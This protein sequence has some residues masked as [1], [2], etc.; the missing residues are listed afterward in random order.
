MDA[1]REGWDKS[2]KDDEPLSVVM[3]DID[4]FKLVNDG[5]G[6][7][8]GDEV[9]KATAKVLRTIVEP[10]ASVCRIGG[11]EFVVVLPSATLDA[12]IEY[13]EKL[14]QAV[15]SHSMRAG[16]FEGTV[17]VSAGV[18]TRDREARDFEHLLK[19][20][21]EGLYRAK[22]GGRNQVRTASGLGVP[23]EPVS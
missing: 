14:R 7:D 22:A 15:E 13:A 16:R 1:L 11:E 9:L 18:S 5:F 2:L 20:A 4:K 17:T 21:D 8:V 6:H 23:V 10:P 19:L 12:S 3:L